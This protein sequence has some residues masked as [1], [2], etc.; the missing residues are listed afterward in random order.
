MGGIILSWLEGRPVVIER[1]RGLG[2]ELQLQK[3]GPE[4]EIIYNGVFLMATYNGASEKAAVRQALKMAAVGNQGPLRVLLGG[5]GIGYSLQ[6]AL[7]CKE[8]A[9]VVVAEI[10]SAVIRWNRT[11]FAGLNGNALAD[12]RVVLVEADFRTLLEKETVPDG[13]S[14]VGS[15]HMAMI[16]TDNG[17][18]WL[19]RPSN[20]FFYSDQGLNLLAGILEPSGVAS[21]WCSSREAEFEVQLN[22]YFAGVRFRCVPEKTG[23]EGCFYLAR[24]R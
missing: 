12:P 22:N 18:S 8:V 17:S 16:D 24:R 10:E 9:Q 1:C 11:V 2:G 13:L 7:A 5:L 20:A 21:F 6:E 4:Y 14:I 3:R 23:Q 19:S 15:Y